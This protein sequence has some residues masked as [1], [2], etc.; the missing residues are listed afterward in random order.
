MSAD[1]AAILVDGEEIPLIMR[2]GYAELRRNWQAT[3]RIELR[4]PMPIRRVVA[5]P[6]VSELAGLVALERGPLVYALEQADNAAGLL[7]YALPDSAPLSAERAPDLLRGV[8]V[9]SGEAQDGKGQ[10][11]PFTAIPYYAW[12][13]RAEGEMTVWLRRN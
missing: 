11:L 3:T 9:I 1:A 13:H 2:A 4:L 7:E 12:G 6:A 10:T 8:T 5:H